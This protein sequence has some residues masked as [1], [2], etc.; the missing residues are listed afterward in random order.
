R[1]TSSYTHI[2]IFGMTLGAVTGTAPLFYP[3]FD[4]TSFTQLSNMQNWI[5][6]LQI[7]LLSEDRK[8]LH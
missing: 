4:C 5:F 8:V 6:T 1:K 3:R 7:I 2:T